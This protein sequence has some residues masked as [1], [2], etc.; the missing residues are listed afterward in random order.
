MKHSATSVASS[1]HHGYSSNISNQNSKENSTNLSNLYPGGEPGSPASNRGRTG[2][3]GRHQTAERTG[4]RPALFCEVFGGDPW[5]C[6]TGRCG[7]GH[8]ACSGTFDRAGDHAGLSVGGGIG[9]LLDCQ[10]DP[11]LD[12]WL[13][14]S[15]AGNGTWTTTIYYGRYDGSLFCRAGRKSGFRF[16]PESHS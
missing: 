3:T 5:K 11:V 6:G 10:C 12:R 13:P 7:N 14:R 1:T 16:L 4:R 9:N 8:A 15:A 2:K